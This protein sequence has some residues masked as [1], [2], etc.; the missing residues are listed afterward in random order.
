LDEH[1]EPCSQRENLEKMQLE[2]SNFTGA[3]KTKIKSEKSLKF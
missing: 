2:E 1:I 3:K